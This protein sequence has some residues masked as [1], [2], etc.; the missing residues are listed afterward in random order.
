MES[1]LWRTVCVFLLAG[2]ATAAAAPQSPSSELPGRERERFTP[3][4]LDRFFD[5]RGST[6]RNEPLLRWD[7]DHRKSKHPQ[8]QGR[9]R[10]GC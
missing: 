9:K 1:K 2:I 8:R 6:Q 4:P 5:P 3:S 7:C 10:K